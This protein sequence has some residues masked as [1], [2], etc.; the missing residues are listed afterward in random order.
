MER[1]E[2]LR[3]RD[4][5]ECDSLGPFKT[6][7]AVIEGAAPQEPKPSN[8]FGAFVHGPRCSK[9]PAA[10]GPLIGL[11][12]AAKDLIDVA[13]W[14]TG[15]GNP[16]WY[17]AYSAATTSAPVIDA[18]LAAGAQLV[19]KTI[20][21]ELA[22]SLEGCNA[23]YG[24][25]INPACPDRL[26]GGSSSGS[27][28][29]VAAGLVDF[30][31]GTDTGGSVRIPAS[32][33]G[34]YGFRPTHGLVSTTGV[35]PLA[36][37]YDTVG[38]LARDAR[39]LREVGYVLLPSGHE[40]PI[41]RL[42]LARDAFTLA[43]PEVADELRKHCKALDIMEEIDV[44]R[45]SETEWLE[46][47]RVL[48]GSEIWQ[49]WGPWIASARPKFDEPI[50]ARFADASNIAPSVAAHCQPMREA[51]AARLRML[52]P[53]GAAIVFPTA[54][55]VA[56]AKTASSAEILAFYAAALTLTSIAGHTGAPQ[57]TLPI[58]RLNGCPIGL[59]ILGLQKS[60]R[61]LLALVANIKNR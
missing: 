54:P 30:S 25:P 61:A 14:R 18:L 11:T 38:W 47:Y 26:P 39:T 6:G 50:A 19:G 57:I 53:P 59:S 17:A 35:L 49:Q 20:T 16:D 45:G 48:Q 36:P 44:F 24:T 7:E 51:I 40:A 3:L 52:I 60:D 4:G 42:L 10:A 12:F 31:L 13:G 58:A 41:T 33:T 34:I 1:E 28:V 29:A 15:G 32:F 43:H 23:H 21:D 46:C 9:E 55:C 27:A 8:E 22:F 2:V 5:F 37:S 56:L